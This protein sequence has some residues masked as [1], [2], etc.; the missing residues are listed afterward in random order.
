M[1]TKF[2]LAVAPAL[3]GAQPAPAAP[4]PA[5]PPSPRNDPADLRLVI[6]ADPDVGGGYLYKTIDRRTGDVIQEL[7]RTEVARLPDG[8]GYAAGGVVNTRA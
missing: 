3:S 2:N 4:A 8:P 7:P 1:E 5:D 6:E